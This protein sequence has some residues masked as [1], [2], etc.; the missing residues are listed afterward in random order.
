[1]K[2]DICESIRGRNRQ[3]RYVPRGDETC[4]SRAEKRKVSERETPRDTERYRVSGRGGGGRG[5]EITSAA[6][7]P[8]RIY[9]SFGGAFRMITHAY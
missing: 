3:R 9:D 2:Y 7:A 4:R 6:T 1:M 8:P 5:G